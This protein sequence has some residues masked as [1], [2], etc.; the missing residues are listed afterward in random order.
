MQS[1]TTARM[2]PSPTAGA[3]SG[4]RVWRALTLRGRLNRRTAVV[5]WSAGSIGIGLFLGWNWLVTAGLSSIVLAILP[6]AV[7]CAAGLC[8]GGGDSKPAD[9]RSKVGPGADGP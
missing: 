3:A 7:M 1:E 8:M 4:P 9:S 2:K 5:A 6:C